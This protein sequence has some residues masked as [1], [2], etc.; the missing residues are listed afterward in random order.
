MKEIE[1]QVPESQDPEAFIP[2][3]IGEVEE[4]IEDDS[5]YPIVRACVSNTD[6]PDMPVM[7]LRMW[8]VGLTFSVMGGCMNLFLSLRYPSI[9]LS[10]AILVVVSFVTGKVLERIM[11]IR[12]WFIPS[13]IPLVGDRSICLNPGPFNIK[14]HGLI[15]M[16]ASNCINTP[17]GLHMVLT[18]RK[19][20][21][22][23]LGPGPS[24][25]IWLVRTK[26]VRV[27]KFEALVGIFLP[28]NLA[29]AAVL[30]AFHAGDADKGS[31][32]LTR[33]RFFTIVTI[34][35]AFYH[36]LPGFL[37]T[38]LS[39]FSFVCW[40]RPNAVI[41][42]IGG[43]PMVI[44]WTVSV[45]VFAGFVTFYWILLPILYY[46]DTWN[47]GHLPIMGWAAYDRFAQAY[48]LDRVL[49]PDRTLNL[50]AYEEYSPVYIPISFI[51]TYFIAFIFTT[52]VIVATIL[53]YGKEILN[54]AR[55]KIVEDED[56]HARLMK[57]YPEVPGA[58]SAGVLLVSL[59]LAITAI[60]IGDVDTPV[61]GLFLAIA[62]S[63]V[64]TIPTLYIY[65]YSGKVPTMNLTFE[66]VAGS[67]WRGRPLALM[68][69][70]TLCVQWYL[71]G[72]GFVES[73]KLGHY[74]KIPSRS[75]FIVQV[76]AAVV[77]SAAQVGLQQWIF[78]TVPDLCD[79]DQKGFLTCPATE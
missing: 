40:I 44:P 68:T 50:T 57:S 54:V 26:A 33:L 48:D 67:I 36:F 58:W 11:P 3:A 6:D 61:W 62:L 16:M 2:R 1:A 72:V 69:F 10:N 49:N 8:S 46:T 64:Y 7:T 17:Y 37:F 43:S 4:H 25:L 23:L 56:V 73:L 78:N 24:G 27:S 74:L 39:Y 76:V 38:A 59:S 20:Y 45:H 71:S 15:C 31:H 77:V 35:Y 14:E 12:L 9:W 28:S 75:T 47:T 60:K 19:H 21:N 18:A 51:M 34:L 32:D 55:S 22:L 65:S 66:L 30:N 13:W 70:K 63:V 5:P 41:A 53:D 52:T 79:P 29:V 42:L